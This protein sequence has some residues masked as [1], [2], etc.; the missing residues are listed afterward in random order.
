M[1]ARMQS[2]CERDV[3]EKVAGDSD[4]YPTAT[5]KVLSTGSAGNGY[6]LTCG[7]ER[8]ILECGVSFNSVL[9]ELV[10]NISGVKG[11]L[12]T[13]NHSDHAGCLEDYLK[14]FDVY[15]CGEVVEAHKGV[16]LVEHKKKYKI[17]GFSVVPLKVPHGG[18]ECLAYVI[19]H[20][21]MGHFL[22]CT[23]AE[24][25]TYT[26]KPLPNN[27]FIECN[28]LLDVVT[29]KLA[30]GEEIRSNYGAHMELFDT[31]KAVSRMRSR[32]LRNVVLIHKSGTNF[33]KEKAKAK[34]A[35]ELQLDVSVAKKGAVYS[36]GECDF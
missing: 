27:V 17:G 10:Y 35:N 1:E 18:C 29:D 4:R 21:A 9:A 16:K 7:D 13:H 2:K 6:I 12:V 32:D 28:Y 25:F 15:G 31:L 14:F 5:M 8:L 3:Q 20:E 26:L 11:V 19:H 24:E 23:D 34:F 30:K 36:L 22:F 33:D